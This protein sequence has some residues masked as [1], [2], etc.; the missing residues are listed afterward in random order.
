VTVQWKRGPTFSLS[1]SLPPG[2]T[3]QL[4]VPAVENSSG[5][6]IGGQLAGAHRAAGWWLLDEDVSG[7]ATVEVK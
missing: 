7:A 2:M 1:L 3:A 5:V 4:N 6:F